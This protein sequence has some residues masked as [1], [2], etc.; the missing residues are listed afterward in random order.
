[1]NGRGMFLVWFKKITL[2][3]PQDCLLVRNGSK[4]NI[5]ES[6]LRRKL[7]LLCPKAGHTL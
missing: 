7:R 2:V 4:L 5:C 1:V 6:S 3:F